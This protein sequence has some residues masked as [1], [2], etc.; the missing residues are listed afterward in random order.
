MCD[1]FPKQYP[2]KKFSLV[3]G[4]GLSPTSILMQIVPA[5]W[6]K[7]QW[8]WWHWS[9]YLQANITKFLK[10]THRMAWHRHTKHSQETIRTLA[11]RQ[12]LAPLC[13]KSCFMSISCYFPLSPTTS[14]KEGCSQFL[15]DAPLPCNHWHAPFHQ[16]LLPRPIIHMYHFKPVFI[17]N[18]TCKNKTSVDSEPQHQ[19]SVALYN[20]FL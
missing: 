1:D 2:S 12:K 5:E 13:I 20:M 18:V 6:K 14:P 7:G 4:K 11:T 8:K 15:I 3:N 17:E 9:N 16:L 10:G 19:N